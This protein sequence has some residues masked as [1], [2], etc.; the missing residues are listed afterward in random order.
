MTTISI[1]T[2]PLALTANYETILRQLRILTSKVYDID[3]DS[4]L[5]LDLSDV[6]LRWKYWHADVVE[7]DDD[8]RLD[9]D[10]LTD[11]TNTVFAQVIHEV[12]SLSQL[13]DAHHDEGSWFQTS[14]KYVYI[15]HHV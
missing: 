15:R 14:E 6:Q 7:D 10:D 9:D 12:E 4:T 8:P 5:L 1:N 11:L 3:S 13:L 2:N